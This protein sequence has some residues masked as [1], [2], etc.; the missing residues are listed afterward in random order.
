MTYNSEIQRL[1][2]EHQNYLDRVFPLI[3]E[4]LAARGR[5]HD[6]IKR[7]IDDLPTE[8]FLIRIRRAWEAQLL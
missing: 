7:F 8:H 1:A 5:S 3:R 2:R 6:Q 4:R